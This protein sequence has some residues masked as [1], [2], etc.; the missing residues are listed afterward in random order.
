[1]SGSAPKEIAIS[2]TPGTAI[3]KPVMVDQVTSEMQG[4]VAKSTTQATRI[5]TTK[6]NVSPDPMHILEGGIEGLK[7]AG[8]EFV[9]PVSFAV[10]K[11][12]HGE[13]PQTGIETDKGSN[14]IRSMR[15]RVKKFKMLQRDKKAA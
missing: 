11:L 1:M 14:W 12:F 15:D 13:G 10:D 6:E 2:Q 7:E 9:G 8:A 3:N 4:A 5:P